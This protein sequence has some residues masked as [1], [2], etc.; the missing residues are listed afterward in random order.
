MP[1]APVIFASWWSTLG[2]IVGLAVVAFCGFWAYVWYLYFPIVVRLIGQAPLLVPE[3]TTPLAGGEDVSF[4]T[5]DGLT[6]RGTHLK[7]RHGERR[8]VIVFGHELNGDRWNAVP[9]VVDLLDAGY[10][11]VTFDFRNHGASD[12]DPKFTPRPWIS[13]FDEADFRAAIDYAA[14]RPDADPRGVGVLGISRG[15]GAALCAAAGDARVRCIFTDGAYPTR[16]AHLIYVRRY[17]DI[18]VPPNWHWLSGIFPDWGFE[19]FLNMARRVWG[20]RRHYPFVDVETA[21]A[22]VT[23][24][25]LMIHG[26]AD[27]M[28]PVEAAQALQKSIAGPS[29]LWVVPEARH[30]GAVFAEPE[31]YRRRLLKFFRLHLAGMG[32]SQKSEVRD[33][34]EVSLTSDL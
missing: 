20:R 26:G 23:Q 12:A 31:A 9:Y 7:H 34:K 10:D 13:A 17:V 5:R 27:T 11:V 3:P 33:R 29:K 22:R 25:T 21:A 8:G 2:W 1:D 18:Y 16:S 4:R 30:N 19:L 14:S 24:P 15:G 32:R 28:I 6:L